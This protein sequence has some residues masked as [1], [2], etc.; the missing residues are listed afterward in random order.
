MPRNFIHHRTILENLGKNKYINLE[1]KNS[2]VLNE[3]QKL[4]EEEEIAICNETRVIEKQ[5]SSLETVI[6]EKE[7][8]IVE[9]AAATTAVK[10]ET[11]IEDF[12]RTLTLQEVDINFSP[13]EEQ[14][15]QFKPQ[16]QSTTLS[17]INGQSYFEELKS[18]VEK[19]TNELLDPSLELAEET[20]QFVSATPESKLY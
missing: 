13:D 14:Y 1:V 10:K 8:Y 3:I 12:D 9:S 4:S 16:R 6:I 19:V 18:T 7:R 20:D 15:E 2:I 11:S 17:L 5:C